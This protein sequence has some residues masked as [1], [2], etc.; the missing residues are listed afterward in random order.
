[1]LAKY[2]SKQYSVARFGLIEQWR[3]LAGG[4]QSARSTL[5]QH[6]R[7]GEWGERTAARRL[8]RR[9]YRIIAR[10]YRASGAEIDLI[11]LDGD[12][13]VFVEV[14][15]RRTD[16]CGEGTE[17]VD[18]RKRVQ[19]KRAAA[20]FIQRHRADERAIRFDVVALRS[21]GPFARLEIIKD[22]F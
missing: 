9:G 4:L 13:L 10:N 19:I 18:S 21:V 16:V 22:A 1:L 8:S 17:A 15:T 7:L 6:V 2:S 12:T 5:A 14:K 20:H 11:A 3:K